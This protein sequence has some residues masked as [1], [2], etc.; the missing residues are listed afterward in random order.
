MKSLLEN[1]GIALCGLTT[2]I[3]VA[4]ADVAI[5]RMTGIDIYTFSIWVVVPAGAAFTGAAAACGYYFGS[6]Y[7]HK[8][9]AAPLLVQ[10]VVIAGAAQLLIYWMGYTTMVLEDGRKVADLIPFGQYMD[11][12]LTTAHYRIGRGQTDTGEVGSMGY[13]IAGLQF[14]GF[15]LGGAWI[16]IYLKAKPVCA[17][18]NAWYLNCGRWRRRAEE[19]CRHG[20]CRRLLRPPVHGARGW[21]GFRGPHPVRSQSVLQACQR[22]RTSQYFAA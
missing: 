8:R 22:C 6:L 7:F 5:A 13:W 14:V 1:F 19:L 2:T 20:S 18:C 10:M 12:T 15:L 3:L 21:A 9:A 11:V 16:Y 4:L 17:A